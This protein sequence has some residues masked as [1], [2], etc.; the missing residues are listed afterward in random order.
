VPDALAHYICLPFLRRGMAQYIEIED[1][2]SDTDHH[3]I[4]G[5]RTR[6][7]VSLHIDR[8]RR[9][10][11]IDRPSPI[12]QLVQFY[13]PGDVIGM[14]PR[15][16]VRT[17][18]TYK[19]VVSDYEPNFMP[20]VE[21]S[22]GDLPWCM[23][24]A[25][26]PTEHPD[27]LRPWICLI[28]LKAPDGEDIEGE[29]TELDPTSDRPLPAIEVKLQNGKL[30]LLDLD[31]SWAWAH[32]QVTT[33]KPEEEEEELGPDEFA[34][35]LENS[36]HLVTSRI[37]CPLKLEENVLYHA[38]I[39]PTYKSGRLA[40]TGE[41]IPADTGLLDPAWD[42]RAEDPT[43]VILP[44]YFKWEFRTGLRGDFEYL[45]R[46]LERRVIDERVG[47]RH[48]NC[49]FPRYDFQNIVSVEELADDD[50]LKHS[51][52]LEGALR[53]LQT[54]P[55]KWPTKKDDEFQ[56]ELEHLLNLPSKFP[57]LGVPEPHDKPL[58]VPP[59]Y[60]AWHGSSKEVIAD[61]PGSDDPSDRDW[62]NELNLDPRHRT[63]AGFGTLVIQD[64]QEQLMASAWE[65]VGTV[66][67]ANQRLR[68]GQ[69]AMEVEEKL[70][71]GTLQ[72]L[73]VDNLIAL[74]SKL[75]SRVLVDTEEGGKP[76]RVTVQ[77]LINN[78][79]RIP[80]SVLTPAFRRMQRPRGPLVS[81]QKQDEDPN[82]KSLLERLNYG[83]VAPAGE[84][85]EPDGTVTLGGISETLRP[86]RAGIIE[87]FGSK[88]RWILLFIISILALGLLGLMVAYSILIGF[89]PLQ[90]VLPYVVVAIV[91]LIVILR[92]LLPLYFQTVLSQQANAENISADTLRG[93][94]I[95]PGSSLETPSFV[96]PVG[97]PDPLEGLDPERFLHYAIQAHEMFLDR[98]LET[99][100]PPEPLDLSAIQSVLINALNPRGTILART[101]LQFRF[102]DLVDEDL[103][104]IRI[105]P[106]FPQPMYEPLRDLSQ[107]YLLPGLEFVPQN[108]IGLLETNRKFIESYMVGI[109]AEMARE[110]LWREYPSPLDATYFMQF[111]DVGEYIPTEEMEGKIKQKLEERDD[112][113]EMTPQEIEVEFDKLLKAKLRD[114]NEI[115]RWRKWDFR[116]RKWVPTKLGQNPLPPDDEKKKKKEVRKLVLLIRGDL[117]KKYP[118]ALIYA[119]EGKW[120]EAREG[121]TYIYTSEDGTHWRRE[122]D[123]SF[124]EDKTT[125]TPIFRGTLPPEITFLGF[126]LTEEVARGHT[127]MVT[128]NPEDPEH[129][130]VNHPGW[131]FVIEERVGETR[132]GIDIPLDDQAGAIGTWDDLNW[133]HIVRSDLGYITGVSDDCD[134]LTDPRWDSNSAARA[135]ILLQ[136]P[137]RI[138][139]HA[140]DM[141]PKEE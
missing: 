58:I 128:P 20:I 72:Q 56:V 52:G 131:Y 29:Y 7:T 57:D 25:I 95:E 107:E 46:L 111:W 101:R 41:Q 73:S 27:R 108:T 127:E 94:S 118:T 2:P 26:A 5:Q 50:E 78:K 104:P 10:R 3:N 141:M 21:F 139:I 105:G 17:D 136:E 103:N 86:P 77:H 87:I 130:R 9:D 84:P 106:V 33:E 119:V 34:D 114:I 79:S 24:P 61:V 85:P 32:V 92:Y 70:H 98:G 117:L 88:F 54:E 125:K 82:R 67:E 38:F 83:E 35:I 120:V 28:A 23:T 60:G 15:M 133:N 19:T 18:P 44:Y 55:T 90:I 68:Q 75:H 91:L 14:D 115:H 43:N 97:E 13:G 137:I 11:S 48:I 53:S 113:A 122:P 129:P 76:A 4:R 74:T 126:D 132:F 138:A 109:N 134:S 80:I 112:Y 110:L 69:L 63:T 96:L 124:A 49:R 99:I 30:P 81:S 8:H 62:F 65:Q 42:V 102:S 22:R 100:I 123:F 40:G 12:T 31:Q 16:I 116:Q 6:I 59:L 1:K 140:D 45:V 71:A 37:I 39:V 51:L 135:D 36:P 66:L 64:Q 93:I 121:E 89:T 47:I